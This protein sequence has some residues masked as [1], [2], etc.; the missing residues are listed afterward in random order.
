L[1]DEVVDLRNKVENSNTHINFINNSTIFDEILDSQR[2]P[3][4]KS[5]LGY[6]NEASTSKKHEIIPSFSK[7]GI[8]YATQAPTQSKETFRIIDQ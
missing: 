1:E 4:D 8:K 6:N 5:G 3:N 7:G 2:Y